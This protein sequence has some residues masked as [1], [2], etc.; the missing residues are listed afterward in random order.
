[1]RSTRSPSL[2]T[3]N[4]FERLQQLV[5]KEGKS[6]RNLVTWTVPVVYADA[7]SSTSGS[8]RRGKSGGRSRPVRNAEKLSRT[9]IYGRSERMCRAAAEQ[10]SGSALGLK[11]GSSSNRA[12][13]QARY[14]RYLFDNLFRAVDELYR[15]CE[16]DGSVIECQVRGWR[17]CCW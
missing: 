2:E 7:V 10:F 4:S 13:V 15:T 8:R 1:M 12:D 17:Q 9:P 3:Q 14:W 16:M 6:A 5:K 11:E